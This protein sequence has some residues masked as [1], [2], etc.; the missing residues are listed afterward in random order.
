[1][2]NQ[3]WP[4][5]LSTASS[6]DE[7]L[8]C[9]RPF[10]CHECETDTARTTRL[11]GHCPESRFHTRRWGTITKRFSTAAEQSRAEQGRAEQSKEDQS[12]AE[13]GRAE[14]QSSA[15]QIRVEQN[16]DRVEVVDLVEGQRAVRQVYLSFVLS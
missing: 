16:A 1:L 3:T 15:W 4:H 14:E 2:P 5:Q 13:H 7:V 6:L 8:V 9:S 12:T 11:I 10:A